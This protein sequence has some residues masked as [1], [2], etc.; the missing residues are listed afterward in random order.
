MDELTTEEQRLV[1]AAG[2]ALKNAYAPYSEFRVGAAV[3]DPNGK[4]FTGCNVENS[5]YGLTNCAERTAI[6]KAV[7]EGV[8][9]FEKIAIVVESSEGV[10][11]PCGSC[12]Q[13]IIEFST[14]MD[15]IMANTSGQFKRIKAADL[16][17]ESFVS[18]QLGEDKVPPRD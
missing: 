12:R 4:I 3:I 14:E 15:V 10:G 11:T 2:D 18:D 16:L 9:E 1:D 6:F 17:P 7:S 5:V 8:T 13:V